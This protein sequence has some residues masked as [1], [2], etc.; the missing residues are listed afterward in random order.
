MSANRLKELSK[1][2]FIAIPV[3]F[4]LGNV[5][6]HAMK[7]YDHFKSIRFIPPENFHVT[8]LYIGRTHMSN[9]TFI[10]DVLDEAS[11]KILSFSI[12]FQDIVLVSRK[13]NSGMIWA[14]YKQNLAFQNSV[15]MIFNMLSTE[16]EI[17]MNHSEPV[18][19]ITLARLKELN[20]EHKWLSAHIKNDLSFVV[21][22][23]EL[24]ESNQTAK[25]VWYK[26]IFSRNLS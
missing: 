4:T 9:I 13:A 1:P 17:R 25:G 7:E 6:V 2:L 5:L 3:P 15:D 22:V 10:K 12:D 11:K 20:S 26:R 21:R 23:F 19:H 18:P 24:M 14:Q 16:M 8:V